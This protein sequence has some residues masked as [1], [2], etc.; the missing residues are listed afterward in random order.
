MNRNRYR[1][2]Y[3]ETLGMMVPV[4]ETARRTG[5]SGPGKAA[6]GNALALAGVLL[7]SP[8]WAE[9]PV[10]SSGGG[11]PGFVSAGQAS[12]QVNGAQ[13]FVN[14]VGNKSILNWQSFNLSP[15]NNL[16]FRQVDSLASNNLVQGASFTSLNRIHDINPSVIA[17]SISQAPGQKANIILVNSNGIAFMGGAQVNLNSFTASTL[18]MADSFALGDLLTN[19]TVPQFEKALDG[20]EARG[21]IKVMEG[22]RI[23]ATDS[24]RVMLIAPT[25]VNKGQVS[26]AGGQV[27]TAAG[28]RV[29]LSAAGN[30]DKNVRGLLVEVDSP[31]GLTSFD[32]ANPSVRDGQLDGQ[33]VALTNAA[34]DKLGHASNFGELTAPRGN[35]TM[36]GYA[37]NQ[38]GIARATTSVVA[39]GSVY[40]LAKDLNDPPPNASYNF[41]EARGGR[42]TMA[43]GSL[44]EVLPDTAD[45]T[46]ALD[47]ST[48]QGL[49][50]RSQ[51]RA[52]GQVVE[53]EGGATIH[54]PSA[55]VNLIAMDNPGQLNTTSDPFNNIGIPASAR[56]RVRVADGAVID[57]AGL[58]NVKVSAAR[59]TVE[60]ELRGDELKDS[61]DNRNGPLRGQKVYLDVER[62]LDNADAG[63][64]TLIARDSLESYRGRLERTVAERSTLGGT[65]AIRSQ[66]DAQLEQGARIDLSGG[67][68][69]YTA[70]NVKTTLLTSGGRLIDLA[71]AD[72][73]TRYSGIATRYVIDYGRW[74]SK[75][76]IDLGQSDRFDP[77]YVEGKDAGAL[78]VVGMRSVTLKSDIEG[79]TVTGERQRASGKQPQ[80]ASLRVGSGTLANDYKLNQRVVLGSEMPSDVGA[81]VLNAGLF[82]KDRIANL[83]IFSNQ[84]AE[85]RDALRLPQAGGVRITAKGV[86]VNADIEAGA[87]IIALNARS[88]SVDLATVPLDVSVADGVTL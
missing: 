88:N 12:Y 36:I 77:G 54:A 8:A 55:D 68:V 70:A 17:G 43:A 35:V 14:Q 15:G 74:N 71:D 63:L 59:N 48:G 31:D 34:E 41:T 87:G 30:A 81:L 46:G 28:S 26:A 13:A 3:N 65:V 33:T 39:N 38:N 44:T 49:A 47:G 6:S 19:K 78:S 76:T 61:P 29:F 60:V 42:V 79:R 4:S 21:F 69:D 11:I 9:M 56:A 80:G 66:G 16:Q 24:G 86:T 57:V 22:A 45:P 52:L 2:V 53:M 32:T 82:G 23:S 25:V 73:T 83:E 64:Q 75:E 72:A 1:L 10:P 51:V 84:A 67:S 40:L 58:R 5:K 18:N 50:Q 37:V 62:A 20:G 85:V 27:I 7:A